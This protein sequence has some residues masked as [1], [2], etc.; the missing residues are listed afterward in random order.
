MKSRRNSSTAFI[1]KLRKPV[2]KNN[3]P[4]EIDCEIG[5]S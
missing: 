5:K 4:F 3:K 1:T 2:L